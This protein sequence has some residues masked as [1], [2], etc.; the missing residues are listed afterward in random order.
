V[1]RLRRRADAVP[2]RVREARRQARS[3][4]ARERKRKSRPTVATA[5]DPR[6]SARGG[7]PRETHW[8]NPPMAPNPGSPDRPRRARSIGAERARSSG[9]KARDPGT[10]ARGSGGR[11]GRVRRTSTPTALVFA[12]D[13][14]RAL[15]SL[16]CGVGVR[17]RSARDGRRRCA[18]PSWGRLSPSVRAFSACATSSSRRAR[19]RRCGVVP[20][21]GLACDDD[22]TFHVRP[23]G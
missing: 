17:W 18:T 10:G 14:T 6:G 8:R 4:R 9:A 15:S 23:G 1:S 19:K 20:S 21:G 11:G 16:R 5:R 12:R 22:D 13:L 2:S 7:A 3:R